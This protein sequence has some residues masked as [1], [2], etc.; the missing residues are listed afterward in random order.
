MGI[1]GYH[2]F[3]PIL[4]EK[5]IKLETKQNETKLEPAPQSSR[6]NISISINP[7]KFDN[8]VSLFSGNN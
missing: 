2:F 4:T 8:L 3:Y 7:T 1:T 5:Q 6:Q